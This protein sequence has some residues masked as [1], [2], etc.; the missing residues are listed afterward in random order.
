MFSIVTI[1]MS[2]S[3][4]PIDVF[5][6]KILFRKRNN[7]YF[8]KLFFVDFEASTRRPTVFFPADRQG[9]LLSNEIVSS[10]DTQ[11][12]ISPN[13]HSSKRTKWRF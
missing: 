2:Y 4:V 9:R 13:N 7:Q 12:G 3:I 1:C 11:W 5:L 8:S 6:K 10:S